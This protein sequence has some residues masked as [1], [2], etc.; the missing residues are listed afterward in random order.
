ME[1]HDFLD[2][3]HSYRGQVTPEN[4]AFN[5]NLQEFA[6]RVNLIAGLQTGGKLS[7]QE[8]YAQ[9][10]SYWKQLKQARKELGINQKP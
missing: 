9:I 3:R 1:F 8:S 4:L 7:P 10:K 2:R 5:A 6:E